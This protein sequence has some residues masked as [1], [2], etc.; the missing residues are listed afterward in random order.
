MAGVLSSQ[1]HPGILITALPSLLVPAE[2]GALPAWFQTQ[3]KK[4]L[5]IVL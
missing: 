3:K 2:L 4:S 5:G 1:A